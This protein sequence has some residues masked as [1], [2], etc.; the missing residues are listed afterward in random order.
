MPNFSFKALDSEKKV[1]EG[2]TTA[3][4]REEVGQILAKKGLSPLVVR[5][6]SEGSVHGTVPPVDKITFCRYMAVMMKSGLSL[7]EG[8]EVLLSES[9]HPLM[10]KILSDMLYSLEQ[11]QQL[12]VI[13]GRY[14]DV[15]EAY[16]LTLTRAGEVSG[17][18][19]D[20]FHFLEVE[21]RS[22]YRLNAKVKGACRLHGFVMR[23]C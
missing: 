2:V 23:V 7:S 6:V 19:S 14:P 13:F 17:Q 12:S 22:E 21:M 8:I 3:G 11:G 5:P 1:V 18:L 20:V 15:F 16:F 10:K 9:K 4:S